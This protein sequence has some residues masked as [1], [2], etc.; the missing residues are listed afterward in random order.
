[1]G[2]VKRKKNWSLFIFLPFLSPKGARGY[3]PEL[4]G[5][6]FQSYGLPTSLCPGEGPVISTA[7]KNS[8]SPGYV[9][10]DY[11]EVAWMQT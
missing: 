5:N 7:R 3:F 6:Y 4:G 9:Y 2:K 1:M 11:P 8:D 10:T